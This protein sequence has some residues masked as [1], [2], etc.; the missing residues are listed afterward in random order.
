MTTE[1]PYVRAARRYP[2]VLAQALKRKNNRPTRP[3]EPGPVRPVD[4][5]RPDPVR[6][7]RRP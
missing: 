2:A 1:N 7:P 3:T 6:P 4:P 5:V